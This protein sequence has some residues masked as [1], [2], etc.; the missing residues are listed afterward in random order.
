[1]E[2][3]VDEIIEYLFVGNAK[4]FE[5]QKYSLIVN[6]TKDIPFPTS[7]TTTQCIRLAVNDNPDECNKFLYEM[8]N[9]CILEHIEYHIKHKQSVLVH[10]SMGI[11]R[12]CALVAC[13]L[14]RH[15]QWTP[16]EAIVYI[17]SKRPIAFFG[18]CNFLQAIDDFYR[19]N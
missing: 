14:I 5:L 9:M 4:S 1:M 12:S 6:C 19:S 11:Q 13:Y 3:P 2:N 8:H 18:Q 16:T 7:A 15:Y 10:C 17:K